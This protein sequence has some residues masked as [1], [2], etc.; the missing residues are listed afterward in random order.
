MQDDKQ[1]ERAPVETAQEARQGVTGTG[2]G[3]VLGLS[4]SAAVIVMALVTGTMM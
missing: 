3:G 1:N 2:A 4:L